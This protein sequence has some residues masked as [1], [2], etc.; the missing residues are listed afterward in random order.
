MRFLPLTPRPPQTRLS[1]VPSPAMVVAMVVAIAGSLATGCAKERQ[2]HLRDFEVDRNPQRAPAELQRE[3]VY[4]NA[5]KVLSG[6][7]HSERVV[8]P[9]EGVLVSESQ[10]SLE[11]V[12]AAYEKA[13]RDTGWNVIQSVQKEGEFLMMVES[14]S[15]RYRRLVTV[16]VRRGPPTEIKVYFRRSEN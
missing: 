9:P 1:G 12:R 13:A 11:V 10:D 3:F 14:P 8:R 6:S 4:A 7:F 5:T 16:V 2:L 15:E